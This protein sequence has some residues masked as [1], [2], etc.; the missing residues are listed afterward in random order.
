MEVNN[1]FIGMTNPKMR[2]HHYTSL[3]RKERI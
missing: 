2:G 1:T 3:K